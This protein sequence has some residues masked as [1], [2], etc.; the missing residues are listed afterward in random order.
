VKHATRDRAFK[1]RILERDGA[2]IACGETD[3]AQLCAH[4]LITRANIPV[5]FDPRNAVTV[6]NAPRARVVEDYGI[7]R[8]PC[9]HIAE[10]RRDWFEALAIRHLI[11]HG[12][13]KDEN[14]AVRY[15]GAARSSQPFTKMEWA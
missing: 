3:Q 2:C 5:R 6:C 7:T 13:F 11:L 14:E 1:L 10:A 8:E 4:H 12:L 9:H 15:Y